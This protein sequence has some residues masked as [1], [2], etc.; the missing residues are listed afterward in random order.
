MDVM[1]R[2]TCN[3]VVFLVGRL[4][5]KLL[6]VHPPR[7]LRRLPTLQCMPDELRNKILMPNPR[8]TEA[9]GEPRRSV[10]S[11]LGFTSRM[12]GLPVGLTR[13]STRA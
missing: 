4:R 7:R 9:T 10:I 2:R 5:H 11:G 12:Y 3:R 13:K 8:R 1:A 6:L